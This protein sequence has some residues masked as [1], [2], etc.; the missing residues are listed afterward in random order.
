MTTNLYQISWET[1]KYHKEQET[2][3][4]LSNYSHTAKVFPIRITEP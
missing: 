3:D 1:M 4:I 2:E